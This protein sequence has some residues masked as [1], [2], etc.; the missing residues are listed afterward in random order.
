VIHTPDTCSTT[1]RLPASALPTTPL[2]PLPRH[3][4]S[5]AIPSQ[6]GD[7]QSTAPVEKG[8]RVFVCGHSFHVFIGGPLGGMARAAGLKGH[9]LVGTPFLGGSRPPPPLNLPGQEGEARNARRKGA[10]G[11]VTLAPLPH[12]AE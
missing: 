6:A 2:I 4:P 11:G 10:A 9:T 8:Q 1:S 3:S 12:P 5:A 7:A